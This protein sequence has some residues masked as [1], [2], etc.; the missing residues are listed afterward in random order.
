VPLFEREM[1]GD[2]AAYLLT[3]FD[4]AG[5]IRS[6]FRE[7]DLPCSEHSMLSRSTRAP[8]QGEDSCQGKG[9]FRLFVGLRLTA[10][11]DFVPPTEEVEVTRMRIG[12]VN[13]LS[14]AR[15]AMQRVLVSSLHHEVAWTAND[16]GEAIAQ[17][18]EDLPD[19]I[20][21]DLFMPRIDGVE[22]T[23]Q[24][25]SESPCAILLVTSTVSGHLDKVY[26][27]MGHGA[28]DAIDTP[29]LGPR[30]ELG[31]TQLLLNK[32]ESIGQLIGKPTASSQHQSGGATYP[33]PSAG[34]SLPLPALHGL[35]V[36]GASTGGPHALVEV[37]SG[38]PATCDAGIIIVQ[39]VDSSFSQ[40][41]G[42]WLSEQTGRRVT[43][44]TE[45][46][47]PGPGEVLL[48]GTHDHVI[49]SEYRRLNYSTEPRMNSCRPSV[50][51]FFESLARNWPMAGVAVLLTGVGRDGAKGLL[52]LRR[53]GW[54]TIAQEPSSS[55]VGDMPR[56]A[57]EIGAAQEILPLTQIA[58][59]I[60]RQRQTEHL[61][62]ANLTANH[63]GCQTE[64]HVLW[65][66]R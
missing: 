66:S 36:L 55:V 35:I 6:E 38:L 3:G 58:D 15:L 26:D 65:Q 17:A 48:A 32:I 25:M 46:R 27:A 53:R 43:L 5:P 49:L 23:R 61:S 22:A 2:L 11:R 7:L 62:E 50:D 52:Q 54:W 41:L 29:T 64:E 63:P 16:G 45:G 40:G 57:V 56:S 42:R 24:I 1:G 19:L 14:V 33:P 28:L 44:I 9:I 37:L 31:G 20:L 51:V 8:T 13:D 59:A 4:Q 12:I 34:A 30:G 60:T 18:R 39:H 47:V 21:M 10:S